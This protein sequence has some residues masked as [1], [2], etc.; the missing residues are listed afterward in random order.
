MATAAPARPPARAE[1]CD[2]A[3][4]VDSDDYQAV[5]ESWLRT[6]ETAGEASVKSRKL[7][8]IVI[9]A[10]NQVCAPAGRG[11]GGAPTHAALRS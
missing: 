1:A 6:L 7:I 10:V 8:V 11:G 9:D 2:L 3:Y 4:E 5:K